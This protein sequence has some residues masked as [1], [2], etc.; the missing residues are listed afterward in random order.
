MVY[1]IISFNHITENL[2]KDE[3]SKLKALYKTY[4]RLYA[5]YQWK[6]KKLRRLKLSLELTSIGLT[7]IG[8]I[9]GSIT[10]NPIILGSLAGSGIMVQA[11]LT[12]TDLNK[13]VNKCKF[14][15]TSYNKVLIQLKSFLRGLP[16]DENIFLSDL[17]VMDDIIID[18]CPSIEKYS[19]KYNKTFI[20]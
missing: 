20:E 12:K 2:S 4:H 17:K 8:A 16:Y 15:Y 11:Y 7:S 18:N 13:R 5:C 14:A 9:V 3:I 1:K 19:S 6:Y 10:L